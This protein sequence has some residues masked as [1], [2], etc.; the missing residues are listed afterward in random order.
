MLIDTLNECI[1]DMKTVHEMETASA[2][3][4][5]QATADYNFKQLILKLKQMI[6]EVNLAVD[7]SEF[8]PSSNVISAL[9]S[10][11]GSCDKVV[12]AGA[13]NNSTTQ[14]IASESKKLYVVIGQEWTE[15]YLKATANILS[16]LDTVKGIIP[17]EN[18]AIYATNKIKKAASWNTSIVNYNYL[19]QGI[20]EASKIIEDLDLDEDSEV[21]AFLKLVSEGNATISNLTD[22]ILDWIKSKDI[23]NRM[24]ISL[25]VV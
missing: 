18:K 25:P 4:Q 19:K 24:Y 9:K 23:A 1:I 16:L 3:T 22:E 8:R 2:D 7:N 17:D 5:K 15:Y 20:A 14:Y 21:F 13:A 6:D 11:L 12:Q 10:F